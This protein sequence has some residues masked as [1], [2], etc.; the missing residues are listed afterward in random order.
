VSALLAL[1]LVTAGDPQ[2]KNVRPKAT[3]EVLDSTA[4]VDDVISK[5]RA[6][7][8]DPK[9]LKDDRPPLPP[10]ATPEKRQPGKGDKPSKEKKRDRGD[11]P[12]R[13]RLHHH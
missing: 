8:P 3:V 12:D 13:D 6:K 10:D 4:D 7:K 9:E 11:H 2:Q 1:V 5:L